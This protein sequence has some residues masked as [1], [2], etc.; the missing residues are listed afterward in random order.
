MKVAYT[1]EVVSAWE[2]PN[3]TLRSEAK[4]KSNKGDSWEKFNQRIK[5]EA[6]GFLDIRKPVVRRHSKVSIK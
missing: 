2:P 6:R 3:P 4:R 5:R 1:S